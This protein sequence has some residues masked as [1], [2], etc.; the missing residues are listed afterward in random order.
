MTRPTKIVAFSFI[1]LLTIPVCALAGPVPDTGQTQSYTDTFGEDSDY[2][3]NPPSYTK[4]DAN[5]NDLPGSA[6]S[7]VMVKDNVTGLIW[8]VKTDDG[9]LHDRN[10]KY[11]WQDAQDVF[12]AGVNAQ[13]FGGYSDWRLPTIKELSSIV[14]SGVYSPAIDT[15]YFPNTVVSYAWSIYWSST[16]YDALTSYAWS[17]IFGEGRVDSARKSNWYYVRAVRGGQSG[18][19]DNLVINGD[20]TV[21]DT[22]TGLMWQQETGEHMPWEAA[23]GYCENLSL[24][25]YDD[26]RLPNRNELQSLVDYGK[27][28]LATD[29]SAFPGI[30]SQY[31]WSSTSYSSS[32]GLMAWPVSFQCGS[33]FAEHKS[34]WWYVRAVHG[35]QSGSLGPLVVSAPNLTITTSGN[36]VTLSWNAVLN[37]DGYYLFADVSESGVDFDGAFEYQFDLGNVTSASFD[38]WEGACFYVALQAYNSDGSSDFSNFE[39]IFI[40]PSQFVTLPDA[41]A[42]IVELATGNSL[43]E[44]YDNGKK[45][46]FV[47]GASFG[48]GSGQ[49]SKASRGLTLGF[50]IYIDLAD[51]RG[52]TSEG[53]AGWVTVWADLEG[54]IGLSFGLPVSAKITAI[55]IEFSN[56]SQADADKLFSISVS[57]PSLNILV[58]SITSGEI[59]S[60]G[61]DLEW[62]NFGLGSSVI[63]LSGSCTVVKCEVQKS[64]LSAAFA[65]TQMMSLGPIESS[66]AV[67]AFTNTLVEAIGQN[68]ITNGGVPW[69]WHTVSD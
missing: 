8:E 22:S 10:D 57:G 56:T 7:W 43:L 39:Y 19:L 35:G 31:Y 47:M 16:T 64:I 69:R 37:A 28:H 60:E 30:M 3:I 54:S 68:I 14:N 24:A 50:D 27:S 41:L 59:G 66:L 48:I 17:M 36:T 13:S 21:T 34:N 32:T 12:I 18:S 53:Q 45:W 67:N 62:G 61:V 5:G 4:L 63:D 49:G 33:G 20:G 65:T 29:T 44:D 11:S 58:V 6:T 9:S 2:T 23:L 42:A 25:G 55:P 40:Q 1:I 46:L 38:L 51:W 26:W 15:D 52:I